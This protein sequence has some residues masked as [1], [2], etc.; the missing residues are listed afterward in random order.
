MNY[1]F[2]FDKTLFNNSELTERMIKIISETIAE[3][4]GNT[5]LYSSLYNECKS[6]YNSNPDINELI[7]QI[8]NS[9]GIDKVKLKSDLELIIKNSKDLVYNHSIPTLE[10]LKKQGHRI[11][12]LSNCVDS[13]ENQ[14]LKFKA[15]DLLQYASATIATNQDTP[16]VDLDTSKENVIFIEDENKNK[17]KQKNKSDKILY[18]DFDNTLFDTPKLT[19]K[20][21]TT[22][23]NSIIQENRL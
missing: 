1:Y 8:S 23:T 15:S 21:I 12:F 14:L 17:P 4:L 5:N 2:N 20:M 13:L 9:Y 10:K 11:F 3:K 18:V 16:Q 7:N 22:I 19:E 6:I